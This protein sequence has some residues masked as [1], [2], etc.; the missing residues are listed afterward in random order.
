MSIAL[1]DV[2]TTMDFWPKKA[3]AGTLTLDGAAV[4]AD[5]TIDAINTAKK[6]ESLKASGIARFM[7]EI[8]YGDVAIVI[9]K[10]KNGMFD[11]DGSLAEFLVSSRRKNP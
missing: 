10:A 5:A 7:S 9:C 3:F 2:T 8:N 11:A 4:T 6:G 1:G